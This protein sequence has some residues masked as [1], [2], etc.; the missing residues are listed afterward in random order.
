MHDPAGFLR[1]EAIPLIRTVARRLDAAGHH[2]TVQDLLDLPE[3]ALRFLLWPHP[4]PLAGQGERLLLTLELTV[5][6]VEQDVLAAR[7]WTGSRPASG[8]VEHLGTV[9]TAQLTP[10]WIETQVLAFVEVAL[11][12]A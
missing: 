3:P 12:R 5:G 2:S 9:I 8:S 7:Y 10:S 4:G 11:Q 1:N 6:E